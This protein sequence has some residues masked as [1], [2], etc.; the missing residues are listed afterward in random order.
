MSSRYHEVYEN[1]RR[2]PARFWADAAQDIDWFRPFDKA[3]DANDGVYGRWFPG[4]VCNTCFNAV[5]RHVERGRADQLALIHDSAMTGRVRRY[6]FREL[7]REVVALASVLANQGVGKGDRVII[8][9]PMVP[10][11]LF[12]MLACARLGA[13]HCV[14]FGGFAARELASRIDDAKPKLGIP[15][16]SGVGPDRPVADMRVPDDAFAPARHTPERCLTLQR[17]EQP[18]DLTPGRER[19][20]ADQMER[21]EAAGAWLDCVPVAATD[22]LYVLYTS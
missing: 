3:F 2:D 19:D 17:H 10:E 7:Q 8:Y 12:A 1:W 11:A 15:A 5:D 20:L 13:I 16:S 4:A 9:M 14:V 6:T 18:C 22:P 21:E